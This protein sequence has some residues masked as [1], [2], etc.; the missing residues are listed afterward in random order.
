MQ[1]H[2]FQ[3]A[4]TQML[5]KNQQHSRPRQRYVAGQHMDL[6]ETARAATHDS[7]IQEFGGDLPDTVTQQSYTLTGRESEEAHAAMI[8]ALHISGKNYGDN[9]DDGWYFDEVSGEE[10]YEGSYERAARL[11]RETY[12]DIVSM[13]AAEP[14]LKLD[15]GVRQV[16]HLPYDARYKYHTECALMAFGGNALSIAGIEPDE[17]DGPVFSE[18]VTRNTI[19]DIWPRPV[20]AQYDLPWMLGALT[21]EFAEDILRSKVR[22]ITTIGADLGEINDRLV[23]PLRA[24]NPDIECTISATVSSET[25]PLANHMVVVNAADGEQVSVNDPYQK[26]PVDWDARTFWHRWVPTN[27]QAT[28]AVIQPH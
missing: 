28:I 27:L 21:T 5:H 9:G 26:E 8:K 2:E 3:P 24:R 13:S 12:R 16:P 23:A 14:T 22:V 15:G 11:R 1:V 6:L 19:Y 7:W 17:A 20:G 18:P 25:H 10:R 4:L